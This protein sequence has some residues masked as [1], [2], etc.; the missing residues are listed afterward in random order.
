M[1]PFFLRITRFG[2]KKFKKIIRGTPTICRKFIRFRRNKV[3]VIMRA[4]KTKETE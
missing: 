3:M 1:V 2:N 4:K